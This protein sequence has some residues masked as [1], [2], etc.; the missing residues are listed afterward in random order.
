[1]LLDGLNVIDWMLSLKSI[2]IPTYVKVCGAL[3]LPST[4]CKIVVVLKVVHA[5]R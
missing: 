3:H 5:P 4:V 2:L 1:M